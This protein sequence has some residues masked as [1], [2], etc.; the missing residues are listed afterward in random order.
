MKYLAI[1]LT[2]F[3]CLFLFFIPFEQ[4]PVHAIVGEMVCSKI[5]REVQ[6]KFNIVEIGNGGGM[7]DNVKLVS[8]DFN[9]PNIVDKDEARLLLITIVEFF[10][11]R[12]NENEEIRP[13]LSNYPFEIKNVIIILS[14]MTKNG[15]QIFDPFIATAI[16]MQGKILYATNDPNNSLA[17]KNKFIETYEEA[18]AILENSKVIKS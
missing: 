12:I 11:E 2:H 10:L 6:Q 14:F 17:R 8:F 9:C 13:Y 16:C 1:I 18:L 5:S 3:I 15:D 7:R 4:Q